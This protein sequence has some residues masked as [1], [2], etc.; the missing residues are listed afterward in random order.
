MV[1]KYWLCDGVLGI[2]LKRHTMIQSVLTS[3]GK[4]PIIGIGGSFLT[5]TVTHLQILQIIAAVLGIVI[6]VITA[7]I[8]VLELRDKLAEE[9]KQ[10]K[11]APTRKARTNKKHE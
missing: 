9:R 4:K 2:Y 5:V 1:G 6:A 3:L 11:P 10:T 8:K 7:I